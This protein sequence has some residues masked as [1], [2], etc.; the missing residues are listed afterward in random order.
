MFLRAEQPLDFDDAYQYL[1]A[2]THGYT[3]VSFDS[4]FDKT[5]IGR[6]TPSQ[7]LTR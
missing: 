6:K 3:R 7:A 5:A 2:T 1:A 4:D